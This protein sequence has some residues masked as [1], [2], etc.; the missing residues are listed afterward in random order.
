[1][2]ALLV[3]LTM[4]GCATSGGD[5]EASAGGGEASLVLPDLSTVTV[6]GGGSGR[7]LLMLGLLICAFGLGFGLIVYS[8]LK[9]M[10]V[11]ASMR[12][13]SELIYSTCKA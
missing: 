13:I 2:G 9:R 8:Q 3:P 1:M 7:A 4:A 12:E 11:H 5:G 10:P 6:V